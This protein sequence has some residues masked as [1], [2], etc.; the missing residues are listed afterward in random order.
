[1]YMLI[2]ATIVVIAGAAFAV[3]CA[4]ALSGEITRGQGE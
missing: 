2:I 1:M 4:F 3:V